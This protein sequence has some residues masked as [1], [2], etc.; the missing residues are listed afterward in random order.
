VLMHISMLCTMETRKKEWGFEAQTS[1]LRKRIT[2]SRKGIRE[3]NEGKHD[4]RTE[5]IL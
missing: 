5:C 3:S 1:A 2:W 4:E